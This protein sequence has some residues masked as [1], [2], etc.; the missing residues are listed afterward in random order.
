VRQNELD[1]PEEVLGKQAK[2]RKL[3]SRREAAVTP[4]RARTLFAQAK[5]AKVAHL[6]EIASRKHNRSADA[7]CEVACCLEPSDEPI[8]DDLFDAIVEK[9]AELAQISLDKEPD[10]QRAARELLA[11]AQPRAKRD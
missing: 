10:Y 11:K 7:T 4:F 9:V 5:V 6:L 3:K 8:E 2:E 1:V